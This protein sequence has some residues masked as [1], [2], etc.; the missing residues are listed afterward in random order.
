MKNAVCFYRTLIYS[1]F[2]RGTDTSFFL[3][4]IANLLKPSLC[5]DIAGSAR[6]VSEKKL[7]ALRI[8]YSRFFSRL[9]PDSILQNKNCYYE[10][11][12]FFSDAVDK[13][14]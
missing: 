5:N 11:S 4:A 2:S 6:H 12:C 7:S 9:V 10:I 8:K 1:S 13:A 3:A 14:L